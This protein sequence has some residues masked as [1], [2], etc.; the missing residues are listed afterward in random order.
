MTL[1]SWG[2]LFLILSG[3]AGLFAFGILRTRRT[4]AFRVV[5]YMLVVMFLATVL[6]GMFQKP[7]YGYDPIAEHP[8]AN[9]GNPSGY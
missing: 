2:L 6:V 4:L 5:F 3:I 7:P 8:R 1:I 9:Q